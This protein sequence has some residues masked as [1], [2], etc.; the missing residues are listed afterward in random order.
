MASCFVSRS[1]IGLPDPEPP[2]DLRAVAC[3]REHTLGQLREVVEACGGFLLTDK[4]SAGTGQS[5]LKFE[6]PRRSAF[7]LYSG[8]LAAELDLCRD[9]HLRLTGLCTLRRYHPLRGGN[10]S[11][12]L[13]L[14]FPEE[15]DRGSGLERW[16]A[17]DTL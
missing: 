10:V 6:V 16:D 17:A 5:S 12:Q 8:L 9:S 11:L 15:N 1:Q 2:V 7:D 4:A 14:T 3:D 13:E